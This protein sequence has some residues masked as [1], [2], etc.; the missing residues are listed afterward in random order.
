MELIEERLNSYWILLQLPLLNEG[1]AFKSQ[2]I[3]EPSFTEFGCKDYDC[4]SQG[5]QSSLTEKE[6]RPVIIVILL[7]C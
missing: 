4:T 2:A 1:E 3:K 7:L 6:K 5:A